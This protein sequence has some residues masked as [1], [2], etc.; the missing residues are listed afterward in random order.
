[1]TRRVTPGPPRH[2]PRVTARC[3]IAAVSGLPHHRPTMPTATLDPTR[4]LDITTRSGLLVLLGTPPRR[5]RREDAAILGELKAERLLAID[6]GFPGTFRVRVGPAGR[7]TGRPAVVH[8]LRCAGQALVLGDETLLSAPAGLR[9]PVAPG[10]WRAEVRATDS[11]DADA[12][13]YTVSLSPVRPGEQLAE[14]DAVP[15]VDPARHPRAR[16]LPPAVRAEAKARLQRALRDA[17]LAGRRVALDA[18]V[19]TDPRD[20]RTLLLRAEARR[21]SGELG[22]AL[23]DAWRATVVAPND[24]A[25]WSA[26][27]GLLE[28]AGREG[29]AADAARRAEELTQI[30][31][32]RKRVRGTTA[33]TR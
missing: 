27:A 25:T 2:V 10:R 14:A 16:R 15:L 24:P 26:L 11:V 19:R 31:G 12:P 5:P 32:G 28:E 17:D 20:A 23:D 29:V 3:P 13:D 30:A 18:Y 22:A 21:E 4:T 8:A 6:A 9:V 1:M 33:R 7:E